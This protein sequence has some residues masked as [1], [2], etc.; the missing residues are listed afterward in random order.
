MGRPIEG[1]VSRW[2][3]PVQRPYEQHSKATFLLDLCYVVEFLLQRQGDLRVERMVAMLD[4]FVT[5][6]RGP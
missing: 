4:D 2:G 6:W 5:R 3:S 1:R